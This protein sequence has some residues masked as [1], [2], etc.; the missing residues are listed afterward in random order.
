MEKIL[1][2]LTD[3]LIELRKKTSTTQE[4]IFKINAV[5]EEIQ[6]NQLNKSEIEK[7][8]ILLATGYFKTKNDDYDT[9]INSLMDKITSEN[10]TQI[11]T[12]I[13]QSIEAFKSDLSLFKSTIKNGKDGKDGNDGLDG[14]DGR[15]GLSGRDGKDGINGKDGVNGLSGRDGVGI[16]DIK[17]QN[18]I[19]S[20][21]LSDGS[22]KDIKLNL[23]NFI[24]GG[25]GVGSEYVQREIANAI[26]SVG[27][28]NTYTKE[29]IDNAQ[30]IF[31]QDIQ[32]TQ[33][34]PHLWVQTFTNGDLTFWI[35]DGK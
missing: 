17:Y 20:I 3:G 27:S 5:L 34:L 4:D 1:E 10:K 32:P 19:I 12:I 31:I 9:M 13:N 6:S 14:K 8:V 22:K 16:I 25:G 26:A 30:N 21:S 24:G 28:S 23:P 7:L 33:T 2:A 18:G 35:E 15:N 11:D 29:E